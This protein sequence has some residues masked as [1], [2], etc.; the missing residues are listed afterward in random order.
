MK[1]I[2]TKST[3]DT[4]S[5][6]EYKL[7]SNEK[8][9]F[10]RFGDGEVF[11]MMGKS[12]R[13]QVNSPELIKEMKE[14]FSIQSENY[15]K[16]LAINMPHE[17]GMSNGVFANYSFNAELE[18]FILKFFNELQLSFYN[19]ITFHY[20]SVFRP[21]LIYNFF[22]KY[23][24]PKKKMFIG[25]TSKETAEKLYGEIDFYINVPPKSAYSS[26]NEW[27][28]NVLSNCSN[29]EIVIVSAG[30]ATKVVAKRLWEKNLNIQLFDFGSIIDAI[31][32]K[33]TRTW[34]RLVGHRVNKVLLKE[35]REKNTYKKMVF[36]LK[37]IKYFFRR[38]I[39]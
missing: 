30:A 10:L 28:P 16:A 5:F 4:L 38:L 27:W 20:L 1:N 7:N 33:V 35:Y 32:G 29:V 31:D 24:R 21:K 14:A 9:F 11:D 26:I 12:R 8:V 19:P 18:S 13:N 17:K 3:F 15:I 2:I 39:K 22:N 6:L 36:V 37:D 25:S 34:I 23:I